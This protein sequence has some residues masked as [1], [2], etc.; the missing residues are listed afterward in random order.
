VTSEPLATLSPKRKWVAII[1]STVVMA[2]STSLMLYAFVA[3]AQDE[4]NPGPP[5]ALGLALVPF[6]F[7][8]LSFLSRNPRP[9]SVVVAMLLAVVVAV[10]VSAL[11]Q[12]VVTGLA[13]GFGAGGVVTLRRVYYHSYWPRVVGVVMMAAYIFLVVRIYEIAGL[14]AAIVLPFVVLGLADLV[15]DW[16]LSDQT[17]RGEGGD[18][19][20]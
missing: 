5:F 4:G 3:A 17:R 20:G 9:G 11:S 13:A 8:T 15:A 2:V 1:I 10:P 7:M 6:A 12:D 16:R 19:A 14:I 18:T